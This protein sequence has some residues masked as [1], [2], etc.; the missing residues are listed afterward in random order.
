MKPVKVFG[1]SLKLFRIQRNKIQQIFPQSSSSPSSS[2][3]LH[4]TAAPSLISSSLVIFFNVEK[5][6]RSN[7]KNEMSEKNNCCFVECH[8][9]KFVLLNYELLRLCVK[10]KNFGQCYQ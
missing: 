3:E 9:P 4:M 5:Q 10:Q 6:K 1:N 7:P 2:V 8:G